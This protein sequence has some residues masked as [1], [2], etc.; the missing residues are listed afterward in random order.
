MTREEAIEWVGEN[1]VAHS[2]ANLDWYSVASHSVIAFHGFSGAM[3]YEVFEN[4]LT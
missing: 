4:K 3:V 2:E 1:L